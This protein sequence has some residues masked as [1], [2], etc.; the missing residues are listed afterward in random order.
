MKKNIVIVGLAV[1]NLILMVALIYVCLKWRESG[2]ATS[3][4]TGEIGVQH[5]NQGTGPQEFTFQS[6]AHLAGND[7][8]LIL[9]RALT[10]TATF[11]T[12]ENDGVVVAQGG[13][14]NGYA[15]YVQDGELLFSFRRLNEL[16][17]V[18]GGKVKAGRQSVTVTLSKAGEIVL[19]HDGKAA[20]KG[21]AAGAVAGQPVDGLD[22]GADRGAPVGPYQMPN[23][24]GG[25][26]EMVSL[27]TTP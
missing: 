18:S 23:T 5:R 8:P 26:I 2:A 14:G 11:D 16:T 13:S 7:A 21:M 25:T 6:P 10:I 19:A 9:E 20:A 22:I 4:F 3:A 15:L 17:T 24:F 1:S 27:K 12:Q